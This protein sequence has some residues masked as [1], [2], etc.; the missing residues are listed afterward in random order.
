MDLW[1]AEIRMALDIT[2]YGGM[3]SATVDTGAHRMS[4]RYTDE[5]LQG[6]EY[7]GTLER[8]AL[9]ADARPLA[10]ELERRLRTSV[11]DWMMDGLPNGSEVLERVREEIREV[12]AM[13]EEE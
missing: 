10:R 7:A 8:K 2:Q 11:L 9:M 3:E 12:F 6:Y 4:K 5:E 13:P 1:R